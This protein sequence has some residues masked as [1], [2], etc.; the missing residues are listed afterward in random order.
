LIITTTFPLLEKSSPGLA[1]AGTQ[2]ASFFIIPG[3][4]KQ[5]A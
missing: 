5:A 2:K 4:N 3:K 1:V